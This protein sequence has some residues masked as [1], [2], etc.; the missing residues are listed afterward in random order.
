MQYRNKIGELQLFMADYLTKE[1][2][3]KKPQTSFQHHE[4][5]PKPDRL[6]QKD[7]F[8]HSL[9][10]KPHQIPAKTHQKSPVPAKKTRY[11]S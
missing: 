11:L 7:Q 10:P 4:K 9:S 6:H 8:T 2:F 5:Q 1:A 3:S